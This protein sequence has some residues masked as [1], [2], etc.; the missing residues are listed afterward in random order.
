MGDLRS[1]AAEAGN[2][3]VVEQHLG[4][5]SRAKD[6]AE[7]SLRI[8]HRLGDTWLTPYCLNSLAAIAVATPD[9]ERAA[10][11]LSAADR[12]VTEQGA[13][14]PPDEGRAALRAQPGRRCAGTRPR[15]VRASPG[16]LG[17][18]SPSTKRSA[19]PS[20]QHSGDGS[21][22]AEAEPV[23]VSGLSRLWCAVR[24]S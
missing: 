13:A 10:T 6:L 19:T 23:A 16:R 4:D 1:V 7:E 12:M 9:Y 8:A 5:L 22:H 15:R 17:R 21:T 2:L 20:D 24:P 3:S 18:H 14:W 11:L